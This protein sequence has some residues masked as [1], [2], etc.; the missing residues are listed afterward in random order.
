LPDPVLW[1][2]FRRWRERSR[3]AGCLDWSERELHVAGALGAAIAS[4]LFE[5]GW[6]EARREFDLGE[7]RERRRFASPRS[8]EPSGQQAPARSS[9]DRETLD[10]R[11][12]AV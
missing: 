11:I 7:L 1:R 4:S 9:R 2:G 6:I 8:P 10:W 5:L 3:P 12:G